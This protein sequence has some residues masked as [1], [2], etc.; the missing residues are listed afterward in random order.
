MWITLL[1]PLFLFVQMGG[2]SPGICGF[3]GIQSSQLNGRAGGAWAMIPAF[4]ALL[5]WWLVSVG[6]GASGLRM[7]LA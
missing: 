5:P 3:H 4:P 1:A 6:L 7:I 2:D